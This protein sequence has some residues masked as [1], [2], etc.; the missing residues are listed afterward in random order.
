LARHR[1]GRTKE[2]KG[3]GH[4]RECHKEGSTEPD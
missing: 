3:W 2:A 4:E 1:P